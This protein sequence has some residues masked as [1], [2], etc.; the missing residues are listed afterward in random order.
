[1]VPARGRIISAP[2]GHY[3]KTKRVQPSPVTLQ[4][5]D[6]ACAESTSVLLPE[7]FGFRLA[8]SALKMSFSRESLRGPV[9]FPESITPSEGQ[10]DRFPEPFRRVYMFIRLLYRLRAKKQ[11]TFLWNFPLRAS[12]VLCIF[13]RKLP[14]EREISTNCKNSLPKDIDFF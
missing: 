1:M 3:G 11:P 6:P 8:P 5:R 14:A 10:N 4:Y 12:T 13:H 9:C 2:T 7:R